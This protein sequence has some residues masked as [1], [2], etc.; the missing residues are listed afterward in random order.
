MTARAF[1]VLFVTFFISVLL[2][3]FKTVEIFIIYLLIFILLIFN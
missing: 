2:I 3:L 1:L